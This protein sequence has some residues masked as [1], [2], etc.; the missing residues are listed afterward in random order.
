MRWGRMTFSEGGPGFMRA[1]IDD[2][3]GNVVATV[4]VRTEYADRD[5]LKSVLEV[6]AVPPYPKKG[7]A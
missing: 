4:S 1:T 7:A 3:R 5:L 6:L 2:S